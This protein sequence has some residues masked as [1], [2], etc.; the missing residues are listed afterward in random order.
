MLKYIVCAV[1]LFGSLAMSLVF[2]E[3]AFARPAMQADWKGEL[4]GASQ[5]ANHPP[6]AL[7]SNNAGSAWVM[8]CT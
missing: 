1:T 8:V 3:V 6:G 4:G 5:Q 2:S 7:N